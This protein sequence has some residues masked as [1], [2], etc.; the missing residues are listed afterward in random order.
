MKTLLHPRKLSFERVFFSIRSPCIKRAS[1]LTHSRASTLNVMRRKNCMF[2]TLLYIYGYYY[3]DT[4]E[5]AVEGKN[6]KI[7]A[8]IMLIK[9]A[10][11]NI[12]Y[13]LNSF[14]TSGGL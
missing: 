10:A 3:D 6:W 2:Y 12:F 9:G 11:V 13:A 8:K 5:F 1:E 7:L 14:L 4:R